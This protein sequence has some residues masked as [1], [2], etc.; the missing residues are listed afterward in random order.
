M[1]KVNPFDLQL[2]CMN[3]IF[4]VMC[5]CVVTVHQKLSGKIMGEN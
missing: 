5:K 1:V 4:R 3:F 2:S